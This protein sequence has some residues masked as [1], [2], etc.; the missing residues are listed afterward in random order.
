MGIGLAYEKDDNLL[1]NP[2][3]KATS[4]LLILQAYLKEFIKGFKF[5]IG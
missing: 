4:L 2:V 3:K 5:F 1:K